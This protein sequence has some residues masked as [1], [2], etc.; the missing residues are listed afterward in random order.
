MSPDARADV[1]LPA[2]R[3]SAQTAVSTETGAGRGVGGLKAQTSLVRL[4]DQ[5][6]WS[7]LAVDID[8]TGE[9]PRVEVVASR[10]D[11]LWVRATLDRLGR[12]CIERFMRERSLAMAVN[13]KGR[14]PLSP[15]VS[16][17]FVGRERFDGAK[18]LQEGLCQYLTDNA[19]NPVEPMHL[20]QAWARMIE[21]AAT[22]ETA[23]EGALSWAGQLE[24]TA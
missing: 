23:G 9:R 1:A 12:G 20:R 19:L 24:Q 7:L 22:K 6:G 11:G 15:T 10:H 17:T 8:L 4:L 18:K 14:R 3:S 5:A 13:L 2:E 16:D 21:A